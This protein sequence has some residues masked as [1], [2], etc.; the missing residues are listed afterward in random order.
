MNL[1][2][3]DEKVQLLFPMPQKIKIFD[4][5]L[6]FDPNKTD[7]RISLASK[8][9]FSHG[10]MLQNRLLKRN[11]PSQIYI[12]YKDL[13]R[14]DVVC[15]KLIINKQDFGKK[16]SYKLV[17][18]RNSIVILGADDAGL[19]YGILTFFQL[20]ELY[21]S[22]GSSVIPCLEIIDYPDFPHRGIMLDI[23]RN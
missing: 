4:E 17:V 10:V 20:V 9:L 16:E 2:A 18:K 6:Y 8:L 14:I 1:G 23:S 5:Y 13:K 12:D 3:N 19:F 22:Q 21:F 15:I 7:I 11:I